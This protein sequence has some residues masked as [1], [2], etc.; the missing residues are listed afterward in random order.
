VQQVGHTFRF[1]ADHGYPYFFAD[2][3]E[4]SATDRRDLPNGDLTARRI[5]EGMDVLEVT[6]A[7]CGGAFRRRKKADTPLIRYLSVAEMQAILNAPDLRTRAGIRDRAM[8]H[9]G[10]AAGLRVSELAGLPLSAGALQPVPAIRVMGKGRKEQACPVE[11]NG[12]RSPRLA[13]RA[14]NRSGTR[15][16]R[17]CA[18]RIP[19]LS[20]NGSLLSREVR[21]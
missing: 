18:R 15:A 11:T 16:I 5:E 19:F 6:V 12:K 7:G 14:R 13:C 2:S 21:H 4:R 10:F 8:L 17:Q 20:R 1:P 3:G 9:L